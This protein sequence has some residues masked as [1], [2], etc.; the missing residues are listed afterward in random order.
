VVGGAALTPVADHAGAVQNFL[1]VN[2]A[3][4]NPP[5]ANP[6]TQSYTATVQ[7]ILAALPGSATAGT[8][9]HKF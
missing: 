2:D 3:S 1:A 6:I 7:Q 4:E 9:P 8:A 5:N